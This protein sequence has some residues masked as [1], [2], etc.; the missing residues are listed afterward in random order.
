MITVGWFRRKIPGNTHVVPALVSVP[1]PF[2][3]QAASLSLATST[4]SPMSAGKHSP[5]GGSRGFVGLRGHGVNAW[6]GAGPYPLQV[7]GSAVAPVALPGSQRLGA[8]AGVAGQPGL[9]STGDLS[10]AF[11]IFG[12]LGGPGPGLGG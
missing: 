5:G 9:P 12:M 7:F 8:G 10:G 2:S 6:N 1:D 3:V 11:G 4:Y